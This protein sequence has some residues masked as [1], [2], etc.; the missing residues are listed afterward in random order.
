MAQYPAVA[1]TDQNTA[2]KNVQIGTRGSEKDEVT[3][4]DF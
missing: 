2:V 3:R 4:V 1:L